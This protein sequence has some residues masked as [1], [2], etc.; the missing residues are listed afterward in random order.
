MSAPSLDE[1]LLRVRR[2]IE[3]DEPALYASSYV[4]IADL[5]L[6]IRTLSALTAENERLRAALEH[7]RD[8]EDRPYEGPKF[9]PTLQ[10][11]IENEKAHSIRDPANRR[12]DP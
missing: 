11:L 4:Q 7:I 5:V 3:K 12:S 2:I 9:D 1:A 10:R 6:I 8:M